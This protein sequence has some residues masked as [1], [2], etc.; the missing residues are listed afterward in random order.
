MKQKKLHAYRARKICT[1][2]ISIALKLL[3]CL[4]FLFPFFWMI[5][6]S[7][8]TYMESIQFPPTIFPQAPTLEAYVT[9]FRELDLGMYL[10]NSVII[11]ICIVVIQTV[12]MVP[13]AYA[14]SKYEFKGKGIMFSLVMA[15]FMVPTQITFVTIYIMFSKANLLNTLI[16]Q[17]IPFGANAFGIFLLRQNFMQVPEEMIEAARLDDASEVKIMTNIM[18][19]MARSTMVT[20]ALLSFISHWNAYFWPLVM[21]NSEEVRPLTMAIAR[22]KDLDYGIVW[23]TIMAGNVLLV[24]PVLV[25]FLLGSKRIIQAMAYRGIK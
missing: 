25:L 10:K 22:L 6:T 12:V 9:V 11:I 4:I 17:I 16:P 14:F 18:L 21:T 15:A 5:S 8:K 23:P 20:I 3:V 7:F 19:P 13:A 1:K 2:T 24:I